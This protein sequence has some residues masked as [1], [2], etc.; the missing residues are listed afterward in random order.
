MK[1][2]FNKFFG[3]FLLFTVPSALI[4]FFYTDLLN[5]KNRFYQQYFPCRTPI[6]YQLGEF[7]QN[8]GI[9]KKVF[10]ASITEAEQIWEKSSGLNLFEY[11]TSGTVK[12]NL[13]Y[14]NRQKTTIKLQQLGIIVK[15]DQATYDKLNT[16]YLSLEKSYSIDKAILDSQFASLDRRTMTYNTEIEKL[17]YKGGAS[18]TDVERLRAETAILDQISTN[19][20]AQQKIF[21]EKVNTLN[22]FADTLNHLGTALNL[23]VAHYNTIG[24]SQGNEFEEGTYKSS[25]A[26]Q[27]ID[28]YQFLNTRKLVRVL[29][30]ELGHALG[31][32]HVSSTKA[33]MY[34]LNNGVNEKL[35]PADISELKQ[36]CGIK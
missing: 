11:A 33:M 9:S 28:I 7:D 13:I 16:N 30:H 23:S 34:Y 35:M 8:F 14:D 36:H 22:T 4:Y 18:P 21:N 29:A 5:F 2:T 32:E 25:V 27:E 6:T 3:W 26:G 20:N 1:Q 15:N 31:L 19:L 10:L 12:I 24:D 17:R